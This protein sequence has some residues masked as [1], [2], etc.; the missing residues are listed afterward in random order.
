MAALKLEAELRVLEKEK[1]LFSRYGYPMAHLTVA[2]WW[3]EYVKTCEGYGLKLDEAI[4][5]YNKQSGRDLLKKEFQSEL[6]SI[7]IRVGTIVRGNR[8]FPGFRNVRFK[9]LYERG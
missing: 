2:R 1:E 5:H 8:L 4:G 9:Q 6:L 3:S 7:G